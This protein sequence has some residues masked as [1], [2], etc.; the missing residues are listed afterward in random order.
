[1]DGFPISSLS[2]QKLHHERE[3]KLNDY[4]FGFVSLVEKV[5][6]HN[7]LHVMKFIKEQKSGD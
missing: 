4:D 3:T 6:S 1:M 2:N 7:C 5:I